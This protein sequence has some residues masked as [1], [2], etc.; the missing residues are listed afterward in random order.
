MEQ[1]SAHGMRHLDMIQPRSNP[2]NKTPGQVPDRV[3]FIGY[4]TSKLEA[5]KR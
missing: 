2:T 3:T 1:L 5:S 4:Q